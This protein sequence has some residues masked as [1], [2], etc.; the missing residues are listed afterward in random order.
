MARKAKLI[1]PAAS[2]P[3]VSA[4]MRANKKRDTRP[5]LAVRKLIH[6]LG[7]RYR[8]Y[9]RNLPGSP[10]IVFR[11]RQRV[12]FVHGCFWHQHND[13]QCPLRTHPRSNTSYW[14]PKLRRNRL[15][16]RSNERAIAKLG[17]KSLV[18]WE[19]E[20]GDPSILSRRLIA[21][22]DR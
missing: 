12:I 11:S 7:Y 9:A 18:I 17:W 21:F 16:D 22:L 20:L 19:C 3:A 5:E 4:V 13:R 14:G 8:L 6:S 15:R 10:D 2:S 1:S